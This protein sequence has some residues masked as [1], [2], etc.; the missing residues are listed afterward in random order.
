MLGLSIWN[1]KFKFRSF[2]RLVS[3]INEGNRFIFRIEYLAGVF[4]ISLL[5]FNIF[6]SAENVQ[7]LNVHFLTTEISRLSQSVEID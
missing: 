5:T 1:H 6:L 2:S 7:V 4:R 3:K